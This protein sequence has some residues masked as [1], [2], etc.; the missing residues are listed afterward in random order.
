M[1]SV[2]G[3]AGGP[4]APHSDLEGPLGWSPGKKGKWTP[5]FAALK[6]SELYLFE[7][8]GDVQPQIVID[9]LRYDSV[10]KA[11]PSRVGKWPKNAGAFVVAP[12]APSSSSSSGRGSGGSGGSGDAPGNGAAAAAATAAAAGKAPP[13]D[14]PLHFYVD[15]KG[16]E[17]TWMS[18][19]L[20]ATVPTAWDG[21]VQPLPVA[22]GGPGGPAHPAA[23]PLP[24][25][26]EVP[27]YQHRAL[28]R[29]KLRTCSVV[30]HFSRHNLTCQGQEK[31][32][33]R[34]TLLELVDYCS[35]K[36]KVAFADE[37]AVGDFVR[38]VEVNL[39]RA[40][41]VGPSEDDEDE[42]A[43]MEAS[44]PHISIVY[45]F[46]LHVVQEA[47]V[48]LAY[49]KQFITPRF[50][51]QLLALFDS[52]D[53]REREYLKTI[54]HRI[55]GKLTVRRSLIRREMRNIFCKL[56]LELPGVHNG[57]AELLEILG[58]IINGFAIPVKEEHKVL[59]KR[60]LVPL[61]KNEHVA[62]FHQQLTYCMVQYASKENA[63]AIPILSGILRYWPTGKSAKEINF[64]TE[65]DE[66]FSFVRIADV[67]AIHAALFRRVAMCI[68]NPHFQIGERTL[69]L[70]NNP[71]FMNLTVEQPEYTART[72][73]MIFGALKRGVV[74]WQA[75]VRT[76]SEEVLMVFKQA[77]A[78]VYDACEAAYEQEEKQKLLELNSRLGGRHSILGRLSRNSDKAA[79]QQ[80]DSVAGGA[81]VA[82]AAAERQDGAKSA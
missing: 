71:S 11:T 61:H 77:N 12:L 21:R 49:K 37:K 65:I 35:T 64:L 39:F 2:G 1:C 23:R 36:P 66:L 75:S 17:D 67:D 41:P 6:G 70:W 53:I 22:A 50:C 4:S 46:L 27:P 15:D 76:L 59:L 63:L 47:S 34:Q 56:V 33:K 78:E 40:L 29:Q 7:A 73:P 8:P 81:A 62:N 45:E 69:I 80:A 24:G 30:W 42:E 74:H 5:V 19:L 72:L 32:V 13:P 82:G 52:F 20:R 54:T 31:K 18:F 48:P 28:L 3:N 25:F 38:M 68:D 43:Y 58:S 79:K 60:A 9:L 57:I 10:S 51:K 44:W 26:H 55:Y 14:T 16:D